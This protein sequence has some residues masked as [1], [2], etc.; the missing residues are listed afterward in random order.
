M[1]QQKESILLTKWLAK[2]HR[3]SLQWKR[4]RLGIAANPE[5]AK[6]FQVALRW[7]DAI[8]IEDGFVNIVET[9]LKNISAGID[10][11]NDYAILFKL[12]PEF[13]V[14][15]EWP[16]RKILVSPFLDLFVAEKATKNDVIYEIYKPEDWK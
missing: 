4:V 10:Q 9:K 8:F 16:I 1:V 15:K 2:F 3:T 7:A 6:F 11:L 14:Y 13:E 5:E 12:T